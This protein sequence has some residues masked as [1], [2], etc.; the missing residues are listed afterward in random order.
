ML[1]K[2]DLCW[3]YLH[4]SPI[5][6]PRL[7]FNPRNSLGLW[8]S[9]MHFWYFQTHHSTGWLFSVKSGEVLVFRE[10]VKVLVFREKWKNSNIPIICL[11]R[12]ITRYQ[13]TVT[14]ARAQT[15]V[16]LLDHIY[17]SSHSLCVHRSIDQVLL[18][19]KYWFRPKVHQPCWWLGNLK[20]EI[21][22]LV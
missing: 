9:L 14:I 11:C 13:I 2:K 19:S 7:A 16:T 15:K 22:N 17:F 12:Q 21:R 5:L 8:W 18:S 4:C 20:L 6:H 10:S 3:Q 1:D